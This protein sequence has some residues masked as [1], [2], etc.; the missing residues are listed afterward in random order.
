[1]T[2]PMPF[3]LSRKDTHELIPAL[4]VVATACDVDVERLID[5]LIE[6][7]LMRPDYGEALVSYL[8]QS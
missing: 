1:M 8:I 4:R 6:E 2:A 7:N 3:P 5:S